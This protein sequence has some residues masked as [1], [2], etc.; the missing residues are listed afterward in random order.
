MAAPR[1]RAAPS[2]R[3]E[4]EVVD[5]A[6]GLSLDADVLQGLIPRRIELTDG[7][8][9]SVVEEET[10]VSEPGEQSG[11]PP[12]GSRVVALLHLHEERGPVLAQ[13]LERPAQH[14]LLMAFDVDL[15]EPDAV[16]SVP[17][18]PAG[19]DRDRLDRSLAGLAQGIAG[20]DGRPRRR[21]GGKPEP[22][23]SVHIGER[24][25]GPPAAPAEMRVEELAHRG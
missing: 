21:A 2:R 16:E 1:V 19:R 18:Q 9:P 20:V 14:M 6:A 24:H 5:V 22:G 12:Y 8:H 25:R 11:D 4:E 13:G 10:L 7:M 23:V 3:Q 15:D 17:V